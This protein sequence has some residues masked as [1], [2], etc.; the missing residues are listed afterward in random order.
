MEYNNTNNIAILLATY[1]GEKF[2]KEQLDS[3]YSQSYTN[4]SLYIRDDGSSDRTIDIIGEY[5]EKY[6]NIFWLQMNIN[7]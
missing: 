4:W 1:N 2:L 3:I 5:S 7:I 6:S